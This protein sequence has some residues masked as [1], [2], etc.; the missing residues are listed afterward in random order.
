MK[1]LTRI[2]TA[3]DFSKPA[4]AAFDHALALSRTHGAELT[5]VHAV[6]G[7]R[8]FEW[9]AR[10]RIATI[11]ALRQAAVAAGVRLKVSVQRGDPADVIHLHARSRP[12]DLIVLGTHQRSGFDRFRLGSVAEKVTL[13]AT[14]P[15]LIT[16]AAAVGT[17]AESV[18]AF[19]SL[20]VAVDFSAASIAAVERAL[21]MADADSR[22]T[23]VHVVPGLSLAS[24]SPYTYHLSEPEYQRLRVR[25]AWRRLQETVSTEARASRKIHARLVAGD[26]STEIARVA[27]DVDADLILVGVTARG[28]IGRWIYGSTAAGV[29][30]TAGR[31]VLAIPELGAQRA[32][33]SRNDQPPAIAA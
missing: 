7:N 22:V 8:V 18:R 13:R 4:R 2:L 31:P 17:I 10:E 9:H 6:P 12:P 14:R 1:P 32:P 20:L 26:P 25:D 29:I 3:V 21:S 27:A 5:V 23:L 16:P 19:N 11:G 30:R 24:V 28:A 15:V 33:E